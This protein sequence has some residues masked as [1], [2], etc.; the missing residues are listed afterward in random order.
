MRKS[1]RLFPNPYII[2]IINI[3]IFII[4]TIG[5]IVNNSITYVI[6]RKYLY[7]ILSIIY[8]DYVFCCI[9]LNLLK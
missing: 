1:S 2:T 4:I 6:V 7:F 3:I 5:I 9:C 8:F